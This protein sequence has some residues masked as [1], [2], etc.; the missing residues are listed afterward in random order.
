MVYINN[1]FDFCNIFYLSTRI[2]LKLRNSSRSDIFYL[3]RH[4]YLIVIL[5]W[6]TL[7]L[8]C[9][10]HFEC[11][12]FFI[13][14]ILCRFKLFFSIWFEVIIDRSVY[15]RS[16]Q[17]LFL[18][19]NLWGNPDLSCDFL[20]LVEI[21]GASMAHFNWLFLKYNNLIGPNIWLS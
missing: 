9:I 2:W 14:F 21:N 6:I 12:L 16:R 1:W 13:L 8:M 18:D 20:I 11:F 15:F 17:I 5:T 4:I 7:K 3:L 19:R 10:K